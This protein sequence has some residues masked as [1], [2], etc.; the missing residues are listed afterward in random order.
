[1]R[2]VVPRAAFLLSVEVPVVFNPVSFLWL[3]EAGS[4]PGRYLGGSVCSLTSM[5][6][7]SGV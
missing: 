3:S 6:E 2:V 5:K 4:A 7:G 1:M